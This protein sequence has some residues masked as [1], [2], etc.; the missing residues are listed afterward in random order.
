MGAGIPAIVG[1]ATLYACPACLEADGY[2]E[3]LALLAVKEDP[4][5]VPIPSLGPKP[6]LDKEREDENARGHYAEPS[7]EGIDKDMGPHEILPSFAVDLGT[8]RHLC[9]SG[10]RPIAGSCPAHCKRK[11]LMAGDVARFW[12]KTYPDRESFVHYWKT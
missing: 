12:F 5:V 9:K 8:P 3:L 1:I 2:D 4:A 11:Y 6:L 7:C 10:R